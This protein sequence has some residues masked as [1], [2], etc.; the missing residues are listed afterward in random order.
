MDLLGIRTLPFLSRRNFYYEFKHLLPWSVLAGLVEGQFASVVVAK[1]FHG[2]P[3]LI[4]IAT[5]TPIAALTFSLL[6]GMLCVGRPKI[7]LAMIFAAGTALCAGTTGAIPASPNGAIWFLCQMAAA[8][9]LLAGVVTVRSAIWKSNYPKHMRGQIT[10]KLQALRF[11]ITVTTVLMASAL[12]DHNP[13][14]Y[15]IV[16]PIAGA[17]GMFGVI[18]LPRLHIRGERAEIRSHRKPGSERIPRE[19]MIEPFS[20]TALISPGQVFGHMYKIL[21]LDRRF[22]HYCV[23][24]LLTGIANL[25]TVSLAATII[26]RNLDMDPAW[27]FWVCTAIIVA[28][29]RLAMLGSLRRWGRL[30]D[31][32]GVV[33]F[34]VVN[35]IMWTTSLVF[36]LIASLIAVDMTPFGSTQSLIAIIFFALRALAQGMGYAGGALAWNLGH[37][38]FAKPEEAE[39]YMGIHVSLTGLR[40]IIA[41]LGGIWLWHNAGWSAWSVWLVAILF[42]LLS[43]LVFYKMARQEMAIDATHPFGGETHH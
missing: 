35:V 10:A 27:D 36:G 25:M 4:A 31:R 13:S 1:S 33:R 16:Y 37:L 30:F 12:C 38:H 2:S 42:S 6:W 41:P 15:R 34:R 26:T 18:L 39:M 24:Q 32:V 8:Q 19:G 9:I 17:L 20:L 40:G 11:V 22:R 21:R 3:L 29:P 23:A 28:I 43:L 14:A 7:R 5:A